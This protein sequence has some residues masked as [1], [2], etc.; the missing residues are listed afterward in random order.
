M[1]LKPK[2]M[3]S[4]TGSAIPKKKLTNFDLEK[5][6]DTTDEWIR[7]R[8][9][10]ESR[11]IAAEDQL[12]SDLCA[13]AAINALD[14]AGVSVEEID[15][16]IVA[17]I[18]GDYGFPS[19]ACFI[20]EK[21]G[22]V[23]AAAFDIAAA[24]SGFIYGLR[25]ADS[26]ISSGM[27]KNILVIG[28]ERLSTIT[29]YED[30][31]T[32]VL[33]G[34]GAGAAVVQPSVDDR[35]IL[36]TFIKSDGRLNKLLYMPGLGTAIPPQQSIDQRL[37]YIKMTGREVFKNAV[38][39]MGDA[40]VKIIKDTGLKSED[41]DILISHQA[42][43]RIIDATAKRVKVPAEKIFKNI[44]KFGNTSAASIPIALDEARKTKM[45]TDNQV[46]I[47]VAFGAGLT[48]GSAAVRL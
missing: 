45:V 27:G 3:I 15:H 48:W 11:F 43:M 2:S 44:H 13:E 31:A 34:D 35:G 19:T 22:A 14:D 46:A 28:G 39:A 4:G 30:R 37:N 12:T 25:M 41:V 18:T 33:F 10:I 40:A 9:G 47:L 6:V 23:N 16:I 7:T 20:Q 5:I 38:T 42:N 8:T 1:I 21:I 17:S 29:D 32:C 26:L 24:C 36:G